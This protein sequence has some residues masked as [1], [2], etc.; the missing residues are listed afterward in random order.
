MDF[1]VN[2]SERVKRIVESVGLILNVALGSLFIVSCVS[3]YFDVIRCECIV[4]SMS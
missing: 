1:D 2:R 3:I 4:L